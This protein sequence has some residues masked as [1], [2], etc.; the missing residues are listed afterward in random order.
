MC[1]KGYAH[2]AAKGE[3]ERTAIWNAM[4]TRG[5]FKVRR[6]IFLHINMYFMCMYCLM[7]EL[8]SKLLVKWNPQGIWYFTC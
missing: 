6:L 8:N 1:L 3:V 5:E 7:W 2:G 4:Y